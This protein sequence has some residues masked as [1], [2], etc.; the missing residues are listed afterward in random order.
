MNDRTEQIVIFGDRLTGVKADF[1]V[2]GQVRMLLIVFVGLPLHLNGS[3]YTVRRLVERGHN[4]VAGML[5]LFSGMCAER[6]PDDTV[7][8]ADH[9][10]GAGV[11][12][13]LRHRGRSC[14]I[15]KQNG[16]GTCLFFLGLGLVPF[17]HGLIQ[18]ARSGCFVGKIGVDRIAS[19]LEHLHVAG[20]RH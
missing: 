8:D 9:F 7:M 4:A 16:D 11:A 14:D 1:Q 17:N 12:Q 5:D 13:V 20:I 3:V 10:L 15:R 18:Q 19:G 2:Q 6:L